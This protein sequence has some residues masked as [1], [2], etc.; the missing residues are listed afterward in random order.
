VRLKGLAGHLAHYFEIRGG[1]GGATDEKLKRHE[2]SND[3][4]ICHNN[5]EGTQ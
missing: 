1:V 2:V 4:G 3:Y 5:Y